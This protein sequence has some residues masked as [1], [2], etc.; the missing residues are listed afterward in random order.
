M[1]RRLPEKVNKTTTTLAAL[2]LF[3]AAVLQG[4]AQPDASM[5]PEEIQARVDWVNDVESQDFHF[6]RRWRDRPDAAA[7]RQPQTW[8][9]PMI[10][11][12][13]GVSQPFFP[14]AASDDPPTIAPEAIAAAS[15]YA[16]ER[17]TQAFM[18]YHRGK[19]RH[20]AFMQG[21]HE[22]SPI[23]SHSWVKTLHG[24][25]AGFALA[26]GDIGSLDD[27][28][29]EYIPEWQGDPRGQITVRQALHNTTGLELPFSMSDQGIQP[30]SK[31]MQIVEGSDVNATV[32]SFELA[33]EPGT[34]FAHNN[35]NT[36][37]AGIILQRATGRNFAHYLADK[38]WR[39]MGAQG[40]AMRL[41]GIE[42]NVISYCCFLSAPADWMRVAHLLMKD[43]R[44]PDG[45]QLL[46]QGWIEEML[47]GSEANPNYGF[48]IWTDAEYV[49]R[50]PYFPGLPLEFANYHSEPFAVDDLFYLDGGGKVRVWISPKLDLIVL[51]M[52]YPPPSGMGFDESF[53]PN[54]IIRGL[55]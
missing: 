2:L 49:E 52:G 31:S 24:I 8:Y 50:R 15:R 7:F 6:W 43:G 47:T 20:T 14:S 41:D 17:E 10:L 18:V 53:I 45:E 3:A 28:V 21:F 25:L 23:S 16:M 51:R 40:G 48:Q 38:L 36:Q 13:G 32:L 22:A 9:N 1:N 37:L 26:D 4:Q 33:E 11:V 30:Y 55:L 35:P 39:P 12:E 42:G 19:I 27:P 5:T 54:T 44:L 46:P 29:E 34:A